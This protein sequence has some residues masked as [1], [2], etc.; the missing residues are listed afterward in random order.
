MAGPDKNK[1]INLDLTRDKKNNKANQELQFHELSKKQKKAPASSNTQKR[2]VQKKKTTQE[3]KTE[4]IKP[5]DEG[6]I[7]VFQRSKGEQRA[8]KKP[9]RRQI[10]P[11][12]PDATP[13]KSKGNKAAAKPT[14][15]NKKTGQNS[16]AKELNKTA[17]NNLNQKDGVQK[18]KDNAARRKQS[19]SAKKTQEQV[20]NN[21]NAVIKKKNRGK[22]VKKDKKIN[23]AKLKRIIIFVLTLLFISMVVFAAYWF[24][25]A[26]EIKVTGNKD[27]SAQDIITL[28]GL[29]KGDHFFTI[30]RAA[31]ESGIESS[32]R[33]EFLGID[34]EL[35]G[36]L[37]IKVKERTP[38]AQFKVKDGC[39]VVIDKE[40]TAVD[41]PAVLQELPT[42]TGISVTEYSL[43]YAVRVDDSA[44]LENL[45][46]LLDELEA[47]YLVDEISDI[48]IKSLTSVTLKTTSG[49]EIYLGSIGIQ[50]EL[51]RKVTWVQSVLPKLQEY[52]Y[53]QGKLNV[54]SQKQATYEPEKGQDSK[55][56]EVILSEIGQAVEPQH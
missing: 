45:K 32:A 9:V 23:K 28:S 21:E 4:N 18:K 1:I 22:K 6:S 8:A 41:D 42:I 37:T 16:R 29:S 27:I 2:A 43:A 3:L 52:G 50:D 31:V 13:S 19:V 15:L 39:Y 44:K 53:E 12:E 36:V 5:M 24:V 11:S 30:D 40:G 48:D 56:A 26:D 33:L 55:D 20:A 46:M 35:P 49:M 51:C 34:F 14:Q 25:R 17:G 47:H 7:L 38:A 54:S 10:R